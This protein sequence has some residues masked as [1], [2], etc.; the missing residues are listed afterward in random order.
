MVS[1]PGRDTVGWGIA[2]C[3]WVARDYAAPAIRESGNGRLLALF[4]PDADAMA[5]IAGEDGAVRSTA[6]LAALLDVPGLDAVY[7]ATPNHL[8]RPI[9]EAAAA[10]GKAV[11]CEK[12]M[13]LDLADARAMV[14]A[15]DRA[16]TRYAT[17]FD[18]RF[19]PAHQA[20]AALI[21]AGAVG[22]VTALRIVYACWVGAAWSADNWRI[23]PARA[24]G[25]AFFDLA[26]H[27]LDL[28]AML[29]GEP[30]VQAEILGQHRLHDYA[31]GP[32][33][34]GAMVVAA[35]ASGVL[36]SL[37]VAYNCPEFLPRR[38]LEVVG[39][40]GQ[41]TLADTMGQT[42]GG[43]LV[44]HDAAGAREIAVAGI[45]R[46][47]FTAQVEAFA[48]HL[49]GRRPFGFEPGQDLATM[50]LL[51]TLRDRIADRPA[52]CAAS[53]GRA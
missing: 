9:V 35:T 8:H 7:V 16:G 29:L 31:R 3:G 15:C 48:D 11:L 17:A 21:R 42:P 52:P 24:G 26:P 18:Q 30:L 1:P 20:A 10:A 33:D 25:G 22:R 6:A 46:S 4:D 12:P 47:P 5:R 2:G 49:L 38:R 41:L 19:H 44:L 13:A 34:D 28:A 36:A 51:A 37:H 40:R 39:E 32:I 53:L 45:G 43:S 27:G 23:D 14:A 50:H